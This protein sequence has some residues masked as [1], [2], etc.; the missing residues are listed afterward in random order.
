MA[1]YY[2]M[3]QLYHGEHPVGEPKQILVH[4]HNLTPAA[5]PVDGYPA[6]PHWRALH[7]SNPDAD[8]KE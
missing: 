8:K 6:G 7:V 5:A 3:A 1:S 4:T 2:T